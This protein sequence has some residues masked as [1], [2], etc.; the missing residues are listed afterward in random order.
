LAINRLESALLLAG[1]LIMGSMHVVG[2][3]ASAAG[4]LAPAR[5][6][7]E[8]L[9]NPLGLEAHPPRLSW[10]IGAVDAVRRGLWQSA[11]QVLVASSPENLAA[12]RGDLWDSGKVPGDETIGIAYGGQALVSAQF[13]WWKVRVWDQ[14]NQPSP[15]GEPAFWSMG[16]LNPEDWKARWIAPPWARERSAQPHNGYHSAFAE[17]VEET[18]WVQLDLGEPRRFSSMKLH[19]TRPYEIAPMPGYLFPVR[20]KIEAGNAADLSDAKVI[21]DRTDADIAN[22]RE[23]PLTLACDPVVARF[24]RLTVTRLAKGPY[25]TAFTLA[26]FELL[27][28]GTNLAHGATVTAKD[29]FDRNPQ[30][31]P[32]LLVDGRTRSEHGIK[33]LRPAPMFRKAFSVERPV[34]RAVLRASALGMYELYLDGQRVGDEWLAPQWTQYRTRVLYQTFDVTERLREGRHAI[35]ALLGDGWYRNGMPQGTLG[36]STA[37]LA[38]TDY[39]D[40]LPRLIVQ[41][42]IEYADGSTGTLGTDGSWHAHPDGPVRRAWMYDGTY[43]DVRKELQ[44]WMEPGYDV[45]A[46]EGWQDAVESPPGWALTLTAQENQPVRL[47]E[48]IAPLKR[49]EP[50]PGVHIFDFGRQLAGV[51]RVTLDGA[52]GARIKLRY[53]Q[54]INP[55]G[56]AYVGNLDRVKENGDVYFLDGSGPRTFAA[57][58]TYHGFRYVEVTGLQGGD[59]LRAITA[60]ALA[61]DT[62]RIGRFSSSDLR[63]NKLWE[64]VYATLQ[65]NMKSVITDQTGR[66]ERLGWLGDGQS[67]WQTICYSADVSSFGPKWCRDIRDCQLDDGRFTATAPPGERFSPGW[68]D[69]GVVIPWTTYV[70]FADR[71]LLAAS[72]EPARRYIEAILRENPDHLWRQNLGN[73]FNDWL[74]RSMTLPPGATKWV[75]TQDVRRVPSLPHE[76]FATAWWAYSTELVSRMAAALGKA[77]EAKYHAELAANI[78]KAFAKAYVKSDGTISTGVQSAYALPLAMGLLNAE[79]EPNAVAHLL[80]A[81]ENYEDHLSTGIHAT[82]RLLMTLSDLGYHELAYRLAMQPAFPSYGFM[83]D[84]GAS[85][86]WERFDTYLP[87]LGFNPHYM[88]DFNHNG[89]SSVGEWIFRDVAGLRPDPA[90]PGYRHFLLHPRMGPGIAWIDCSYESV[91]GTIAWKVA[92]KDNRVSMDV[93]VP[94]GTT[95]TVYVPTA[96]AKSV[97]EG[98]KPAGKAVGVEP[99]APTPGAALYRLDSGQ[100]HFSA[101]AAASQTNALPEADGDTTDR[102]RRREAWRRWSPPRSGRLRPSGLSKTTPFCPAS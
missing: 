93:T 42:E 30:W 5:L 97:T 87:K 66:N 22:P 70:N 90:Q 50:T 48:A 19:P 91:R 7:C 35:A 16:L 10:R 69:A 98:G 24:V 75:P 68:A 82:K 64:N 101:V 99:L 8:S 55:D 44:G 71:R 88:N 38:G 18:K 58:F 21:V 76:V 47:V 15:Y 1:R 61:S 83:V 81:I 11:Y 25:C 102:P 39:G 67:S 4:D 52:A 74:D 23:L 80:E 27:D 2:Q 54:A 78:R 77:E 3:D 43:Y 49:T 6:R 31:A 46:H 34:R 32:P 95:A 84:S 96:D 51:C 56:T 62:P 12:D 60:L 59:D 9:V 92:L 14:D 65:G 20:F 29:S 28:G 17:S 36:A 45:A 37:P 73:A 13:A 100:F 33:R 57:P 94:P 53:C 85:T 72:Y 86:I 26:E 40:G 89:L 41:L 63:L 79:T